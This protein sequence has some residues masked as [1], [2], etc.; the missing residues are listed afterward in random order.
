MIGGYRYFLPDWKT[1]KT[2]MFLKPEK[3]S[4]QVSS[5]RPIQLTSVFSKVLE[6]IIVKRLHN[7]LTDQQLLPISQAGFRPIF[8]INDQLLRLTNIITNHYNRSKPSCLVLFDLEK[9]FDKVWHKGL[10]SK[11][12]T[13][14]LPISYIT[15]IFKFLSCRLT[16]VYIIDSFSFPTFINSGVPQ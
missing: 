8:S 7:H 9:A 1:S 6:R 11:L 2:L 12:L 5:Y 16:Y 3:P 15:F 14:H 10:I 4:D 13:F